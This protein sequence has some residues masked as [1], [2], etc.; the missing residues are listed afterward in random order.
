MKK[1]AENGRNV[2]LVKMGP[3]S[4]R[5][6]RQVICKDKNAIWDQLLAT[7]AKIVQRSEEPLA[8]DLIDL[9]LLL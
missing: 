7:K 9:L 4:L 6:R 2:S 1:M 8:G 5:D 3:K